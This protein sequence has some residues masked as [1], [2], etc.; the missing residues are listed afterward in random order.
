MT[1]TKITPAPLTRTAHHYSRD[2]ILARFAEADT[3]TLTLAEGDTAWDPETGDT[4][5]G[6]A[7]IRYAY[8]TFPGPGRTAT[9]VA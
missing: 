9:I 4:F 1:T 5:L 7:T 6:G 2:D 8:G 3:F